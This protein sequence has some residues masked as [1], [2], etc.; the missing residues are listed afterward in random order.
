MIHV[1]MFIK[2]NIFVY[3]CV[4]TYLIQVYYY[5]CIIAVATSDVDAALCFVKSSQR[6]P[7]DMPE[8][9]VWSTVAPHIAQVAQL[10]NQFPSCLVLAHFPDFGSLE[11][12]E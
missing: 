5:C 2:I 7:I 12:C 9:S 8:L 1:S 10:W 3:D 4:I 6:Q 11:A